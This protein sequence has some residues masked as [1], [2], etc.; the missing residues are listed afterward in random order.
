MTISFA[1]TFASFSTTALHATRSLLG[2]FNI[3]RI[4]DN[5]N[6]DGNEKTNDDIIV[7]PLHQYQG[8]QL[9]D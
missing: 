7:S 6:I 1:A 3:D 9:R 8:Y 4:K 5:I 2:E